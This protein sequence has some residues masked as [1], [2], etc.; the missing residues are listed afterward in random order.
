MLINK[1]RLHND[2]NAL[3]P[4]EKMVAAKQISHKPHRYLS[5]FPIEK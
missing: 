4:E 3:T 5:G 2:Y 1:H